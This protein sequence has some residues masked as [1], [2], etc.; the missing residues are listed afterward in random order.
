MNFPCKIIKN[1]FNEDCLGVNILRNKKI[2]YF[3]N[4]TCIGKS[5]KN[6][7]YWEEW[8]FKYI[9]QN[10]IDN[11]NII[12]LGG[13][14]GTTTLL[15]SEVLSNNCKIYTFEPV[16]SD[17]LFKNIE[18]NKLCDKVDIYPYGVG[19]QINS[20]QINPVN[21]FVHINFGAL[22]LCNSEY[23]EN[24]M[25][26]DIVPIDY[27]NF[28]NVSLI[29]IDVEHMEIEVLE[30]C[31]NLIEKCKPT[32]IIETYQYNKLIQTNIFKKLVLLGYEMTVIPDGYANTDWIMKVK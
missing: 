17:I 22:S 24:N 20:L 14:I 32:I 16:Y 6:G 21:L 2:N 12:D 11:T 19:K 25:K 3:K 23:N 10:Y 1:T 7:Y 26:I 13:N 27:F 18:E 29:K 28:D 8:M 4:D 9:Q 5:I 31:L 15:M 30:G